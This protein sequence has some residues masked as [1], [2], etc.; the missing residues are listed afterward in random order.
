MN[1][2]EIRNRLSRAS[3]TALG[4]S[5][6]L[7]LSGCAALFDSTAPGEVG[8][9]AAEALDSG[10]VLT[11]TDPQDKDL[12]VVRIVYASSTVDVLA[13]VQSAEIEGLDNGTEVV[14]TVKTIDHVGNA[15][16]GSAFTGVRS[17]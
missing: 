5:L 1:T 6:L 12:A 17:G 2:F 10:V 15:S 7:L 4:A 14:F 16:S 8:N 11:W 13:G 3:R 9:L